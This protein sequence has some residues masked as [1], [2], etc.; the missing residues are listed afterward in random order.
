[1]PIRLVERF[2]IEHAS[3]ATDVV[4][5][6]ASSASY[7]GVSY[8]PPLNERGGFQRF[9]VTVTGAVA[10]WQL[11]ALVGSAWV[12]LTPEVGGD[13]N[14]F[15]HGAWTGGQAGSGTVLL[16][17]FRAQAY[18]VHFVGP[19]NAATVIDVVCER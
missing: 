16:P 6:Q 18:R 7:I 12:D 4:L 14:T 3:G 13:G 2:T 17:A 19:P 1:M 11:Q 15:S 8:V 10:S 5:D 9:T